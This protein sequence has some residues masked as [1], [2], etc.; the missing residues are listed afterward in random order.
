MTSNKQ[1]TYARNRVISRKGR[2]N[3]Y[4]SDWSYALKLVIV[5]LAATLWLK[6][7][8]P[9][10]FGGF[11]LTALPV[12]TLIGALLIS[13]FEPYQFNRKV[14]YAVLIVI[15]VISYFEPAGLLI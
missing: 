14:F 4:E 5:V 2:E 12:G 1:R 15:T 6:F 9:L 13:R 8:S 7:K 10:V 11:M 3:I